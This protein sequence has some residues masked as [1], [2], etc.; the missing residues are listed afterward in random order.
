M[1]QLVGFLLHPHFLKLAKNRKNV[2]THP[3]LSKCFRHR[4]NVLYLNTM[5]AT[6]QCTVYNIV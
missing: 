6:V 4:C 2:E 5:S 3:P 1:D